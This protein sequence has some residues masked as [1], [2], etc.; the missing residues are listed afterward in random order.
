MA[1]PQKSKHLKEIREFV[2]FAIFVISGY[3]L[4]T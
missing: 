3:A 1:S 2:V 4:I